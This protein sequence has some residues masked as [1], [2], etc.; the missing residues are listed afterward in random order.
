MLIYT[1]C[2]S[3]IYIFL[4]ND[5]KDFKNT[6]LLCFFEQNNLK[7]VLLHLI[8]SVLTMQLSFKNVIQCQKLVREKSFDLKE[9][10]EKNQG[11]SFGKSCTNPDNIVYMFFIGGVT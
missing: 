9:N 1:V 6:L 8:N 11:I 4:L 7:S 3:Y 2:F 10:S 5:V